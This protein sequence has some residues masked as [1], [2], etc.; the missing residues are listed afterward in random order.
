MGC[1]GRIIVVLN[2]FCRNKC[3]FVL[4]RIVVS[5]IYE[6]QSGVVCYR[7]AFFN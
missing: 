3:D 1:F 7:N 2:K 6:F 4:F 5:S